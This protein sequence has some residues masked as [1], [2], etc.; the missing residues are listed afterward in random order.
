M[1]GDSEDQTARQAGHHC[2]IVTFHHP[3]GEPVTWGEFDPAFLRA[4]RI[5]PSSW[6][7]PV[8]V[9][10]VAQQSKQGNTFFNY[11][12]GGVP[13]P[14]G[15]ETE[16]RLDDLTLRADEVG[17]SKR[18]NPTRRYHGMLTIAG[19]QYEIIG[20]VTKTRSSYWVKV[21]VQKVARGGGSAAEPRGGRFV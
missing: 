11:E 3:S 20:Y 12:Q 21:H 6:E 5:G 16:L 17:K 8:R 10:L 4:N 15:L 18:G 9:E 14:D 13:L 2:P 19:I 1:A 7:R